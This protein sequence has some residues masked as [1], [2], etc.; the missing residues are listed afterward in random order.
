[1]V[2]KSKYTLLLSFVLISSIL[3]NLYNNIEKIGK[4]MD[5]EFHLDQTLSYYNNN[6]KY[7]NNKLTTFPGTFLLSSFFLKIFYLLQIPINDTNSIKIVRMFS[8]IISTFSFIIL[9]LFKKKINP[10]RKLLYKFQLLIS[11][12]P[13][14]FF[15]NFLYYTETFSI[16]SLILFFYVYLYV[17]KNYFLRFLSGI[18]CVLIRQNNIIWINLVVLNDTITSIQNL[19]K[20][21]SL[22][23]FFKDIYTTIIRN[24]DILIID[25]LFI[26]FIIFN[27]FSIVLGDKTNHSIVL[28]LAQINHLFIFS[29]LFFPTINFK[30]FRNLNKLLNSRKKAARFVL[31]FLL[32][33]LFVLICNRF[34]YVH[35][36]ILSDNRHYIF[37]Y[38]KKIYLKD[39]LRYALLLYIS[40]AFS[41]I[42]NDNVKLL[43]DNRIISWL[44]CSILCLAPSKLVEMRYF[45]PCFII[46]L[47]LVNNNKESIDDLY[48][49]LFNYWN[50]VAH[51]IINGIT[52]YVFLFKPFENKFMD[53]EI[54]RFMY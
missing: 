5:E 10:E 34:S 36:F 47:I 53:N 2:E 21:R 19:V 48:Q 18:L 11:F 27:N 32:L 17:A 30:V 9:S 26:I 40:L 16:F 8:I 49:I 25:I 45:S 51:L 23:N 31:L 50:V 35:D 29:L 15:Y 14:N 46:L 22:K 24:I 42:I 33:L 12:L 7:W 1:M 39:N 3:F 43:K 54:S 37:Y 13:I 6:F 52:F 44:I 28:H 20:N 38:F 4:Y 41:I